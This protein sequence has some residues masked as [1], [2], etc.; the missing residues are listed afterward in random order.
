MSTDV[1][2]ADKL[3]NCTTVN[4]IAETI[5][6]TVLQK[7]NHKLSTGNPSIKGHIFPSCMLG[8]I[9]EW[10]KPQKKLKKNIT[11][12]IIKRKKPTAKFDLYNHLVP[13]SHTSSRK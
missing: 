4:A 12:E 8:S 5:K 13:S 3:E 9:D 2:I 1:E 11:S 7:G 10:K 6:I